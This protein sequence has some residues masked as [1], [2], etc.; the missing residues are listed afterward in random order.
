MSDWI[1]SKQV[2]Q[3][4][5][6]IIHLRASIMFGDTIIYHA[7]RQI[8]ELESNHDSM[9]RPKIEFIAYITFYYKYLEY[10]NYL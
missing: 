8:T 6:M 10:R 1:K 7:Q 5:M 4:V 2:A 3:W 9:N